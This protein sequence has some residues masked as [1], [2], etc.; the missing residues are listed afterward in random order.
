MISLSPQERKCVSI[1]MNE[2][3]I[4]EYGNVQGRYEIKTSGMYMM[5]A[6]IPNFGMVSEGVNCSYTK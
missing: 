1:D 6:Y 5:N 4:G 3:V 2:D